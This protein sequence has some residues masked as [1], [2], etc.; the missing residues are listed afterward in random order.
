VANP[1][2]LAADDLQALM[3]R[4]DQLIVQAREMQI[5][6]AQAAAANQSLDE[7]RVMPEA[8]T[9]ERVRAHIAH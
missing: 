7:P 2:L 8:R 5:A 3:I 6:I 1:R 9:D 4:L